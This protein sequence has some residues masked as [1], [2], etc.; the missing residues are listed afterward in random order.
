MG[1]GKTHRATRPLEASHRPFA[2]L[3]HGP[4]WRFHSRWSGT[5]QMTSRTDLPQSA[6]LFFSVKPCHA[7]LGM[8]PLSACC[9]CAPRTL[10]RHAWHDATLEGRFEQGSKGPRPSS[11]EGLFNFIEKLVTKIEED[12]LSIQPEYL[13]RVVS[14][15]FTSKDKRRQVPDNHAE[16]VYRG[17]MGAF[18]CRDNSST[19]STLVGQ[20]CFPSV[21]AQSR[22]FLTLPHHQQQE[23]SSNRP[24]FQ[25]RNRR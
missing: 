10:S 21:E 20:K 17:A 3:K 12:V 11:L 8:T 18:H 14:V 2:T 23:A 16:A 19:W 6:A 13:R 15:T 4:Y 25:P 5:R 7:T 22:E 9:V 1:A 24:L